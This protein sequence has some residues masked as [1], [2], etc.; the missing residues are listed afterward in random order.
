MEKSLHDLVEN[1]AEI[2]PKLRGKTRH[3]RR[4]KLGGRGVTFS[5]QL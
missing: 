5:M 3:R 2:A 1:Y 4:E